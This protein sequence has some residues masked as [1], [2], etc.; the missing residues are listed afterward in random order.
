ML[1]QFMAKFPGENTEAD[2]VI[3]HSRQS[4]AEKIDC[5]QEVASSSETGTV[6]HSQ[7]LTP[8]RAASPQAAWSMV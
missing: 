2:E 5:P 6:T 1:S 3:G 8:A 7:Q 4:P